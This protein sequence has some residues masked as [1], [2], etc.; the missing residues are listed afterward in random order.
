[1]FEEKIH[2]SKFSKYPTPVHYI[3]DEDGLAII[4]IPWGN[5]DCA[6]KAISIIKDY[7]LSAKTDLESTSPF[8]LLPE[9]SASA[10]HLRIGVMLAN[11]AIARENNMEEYTC[12]IELIAISI[13]DREVNLVST[14]GPSFLCK[15]RGKDLI[16]YKNHHHLGHEYPASKKYPLPKDLIGINIKKNIQVESFRYHKND[17]FYFLLN[18]YLPSLQASDDYKSISKILEKNEE[19][20]YWLSQWKPTI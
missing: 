8:P 10:N 17:Y 3:S 12:G 9:K 14:G 2:R 6:E 5:S 11:D 4:C 16:I 19:Q 1:M 18:D 15:K 20:P 7:F 13:H